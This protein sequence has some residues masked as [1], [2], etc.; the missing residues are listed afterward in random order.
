VF[1]FSKKISIN[2]FPLLLILIPITRI[3]I[4]IRKI[5]NASAQR[6]FEKPN[7]QAFFGSGEINKVRIP[8]IISS[9]TGTT[10]NIVV[11]LVLLSL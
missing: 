10:E 2:V 11:I 9:I 3:P 7:N 4:E 8:A 1:F 5:N 6:N